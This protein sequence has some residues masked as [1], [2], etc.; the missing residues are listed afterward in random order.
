MVAEGFSADAMKVSISD[1]LFLDVF[2]DEP[3]YIC[4][5]WA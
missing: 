4:F 5:L 3:H 2:G 1:D